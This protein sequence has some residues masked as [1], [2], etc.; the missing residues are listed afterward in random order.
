MKKQRLST[1]F[2][3]LFS[4]IALSSFFYLCYINYEAKEQVNASVILRDKIVKDY[5]SNQA[6]IVATGEEG[7][8]SEENKEFM[9]FI[10]KYLKRQID[11]VTLR[12]ENSDIDQ[13]LYYPDSKL[14]Y[15]VVMEPE[16]GKYHYDMIGFDGT[17]TG[18]GTPLIPKSPGERDFRTLILAHRMINYY[19]DDDYL[20]SNLPNRWVDKATAEN[21]QFIYTYKDNKAYRWRI[22]T[23][24]PLKGD[25]MLYKT[26]YQKGGEDYRELLDHIEGIT[27]YTIGDKPSV[28]T[29]TLMLSTCSRSA[30][31]VNVGRFVVVFKLDLIYDKDSNSLKYFL[32]EDRVDTWKRENESIRGGQV[33]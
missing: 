1:F 21:H 13:W 18:A 31:E 16:V 32:D 27:S 11:F 30:D 12:E 24:L 28:T 20:F 8:K 15:P 29:P 3:F 22:W 9:S 26:P 19:G 10:D 25:N 23:G 6:G 7:E 4:I 14:D 17:W 5:Q 2:L 33:L